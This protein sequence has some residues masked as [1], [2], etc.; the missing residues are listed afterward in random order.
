MQPA[1]DR[2]LLAG[3][4]R[5][6]LIEPEQHAPLFEVDAE[7]GVQEPAVERREAC[8]ARAGHGLAHHRRDRVRCRRKRR[9]AALPALAHLR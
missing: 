3:L 7:I 2:R 9:H 1:R 4:R 6:V 5:V 8:D